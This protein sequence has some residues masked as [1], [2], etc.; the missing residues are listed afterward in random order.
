VTKPITKKEVYLADQVYTVAFPSAKPIAYREFV[1]P[2]YFHA[3][4]YF[5]DSDGVKVTKANA[6][7]YKAWSVELL[8][9]VKENESLE[10]ITSTIK[11]A[12]TYKG[13]VIVSFPSEPVKELDKTATVKATYYKYVADHRAKLMAFAI[14]SAVQSF[15]YKKEK[16]GSNSWPLFSRKDI[17]EDNLQGI[18]KK[19]INESY[20]KKDQ[21]FYLEVTRL[22]REAVSLGEHPNNY[23]RDLYGKDKKTVQGWTTE[24]RKRGLL[25]KATEKGKVSRVR[26]N[27]R[28]E[29]G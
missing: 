7:D 12:R 23:L 14:T 6:K 1:L 17:S 8:V 4:A 22:Y 26:K 3:T 9:R 18:A 15:V 21:A 24:A 19:I 13:H 5:F 29:K 20:V 2:E 27:T 25:E 16:D 11:G 28:K 10:V